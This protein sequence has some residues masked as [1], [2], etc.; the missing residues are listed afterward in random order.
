MAELSTETS[1]WQR[2]RGL[3]R[4]V[5][6]LSAVSLLNDTSSEIIYPLL[7]AFLALSL[8]A[9]PFAIG[10]IE[11]FAESVASLLKLVAGYLSDRF[12]SRKLPVF[13]GYSLAA[14]MRPFL[15]F[16]TSWPQVLVVRMA[17]RVGKGIRGAPRDALIAE[18]VP[19]NQRGFAFG[20]NRA[21]DHLGAVFGPVAAFFLLLIFAVDTSKPTIREYQQVFLFASVPVVLGLL[22]IAFVVRDQ[23]TS[24]AT[25]SARPNLSLKGFDPNFKRYLVV[26]A[27]FTLSNSTD[28]FLLL[29]ASDAGISPVILPLLWMTLHFS[30][31]ISSLIGGDLSDRLGRKTL[32][33]SGW[34]IYALV[35]VGFAFVSSAWQCWLLF[36]VYGV[37]FGLTEGVEKAF[38]ADMVPEE[39]RGTAYG[40][41]NLAFGITVFPASLIFGLIWSQYGAHTA[42]LTSA[43]VSILAIF[44]LTSIKSERDPSLTH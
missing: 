41:Y 7:P 25:A 33:I 39:K 4:N 20:F 23:P 15:A 29:R 18:S 37:Y 9:S 40:L 11:G 3:P 5:L 38:V 35:Y 12:G 28:A 19:K 17:D 21:A 32:I 42:F 1:R 30:K 44:L 10:L 8:G 43:C 31:V 22:I 13:L 24:A 6:A 16:V 36:I 14:I 27:V 2:Y 26:L 34:I